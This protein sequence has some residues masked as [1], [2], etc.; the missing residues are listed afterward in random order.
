MASIATNLAS[1]PTIKNIGGCFVWW[2]DTLIDSLPARWREVLA[3]KALRLIARLEHDEVILQRDDS[4]ADV[5]GRFALDDDKDVSKQFVQGVMSQFDEAPHN[6]LLIG[7]Q[8]VLRRTIAVPQ[9][10]EENLR[11][12]LGFEMDRYTPFSADQVAYDYRIV[13]R[14]DD[15]LSVELVVAKKD[16]VE[17]AV[18]LVTERGLHLDG[19]DIALDGPEGDSETIGV[20]LLPPEQRAK[21]NHKRL[22]LNLMLGALLLGL[23]Y[24]VM[25]QSIK[26]RERSIDQLQARVNATRAEATQVSEMRETLTRSQDGA[27][28]LID[29]KQSHPSMTRLLAAV[30]E[31]LPDDTSLQRLQINRERIELNGEAPEPAR[32]IALLENM[33]CIRRPA[34]KSAY[35]P[36]Q[37]TGKERFVINSDLDCSLVKSVEAPSTATDLET[38]I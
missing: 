7:S 3:P 8:G 34:P 27:L 10:A 31:T 24:V 2:R 19:V 20:N 28:F 1:H 12:V 23:L 37:K 36:N 13:G 18:Q 17:H 35:T 6:W 22:L 9:A 11:S 14:S 15:T 33:D 16:E 21:S 5:L 38:S 29:L 30:T 25:W 26:A 4:G 32:L